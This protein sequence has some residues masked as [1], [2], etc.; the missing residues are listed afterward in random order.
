MNW[1]L[2]VRATD[3]FAAGLQANPIQHFWTLTVEEQFYL[4]WPAML[5]ATA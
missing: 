4:V 2:V 3:Y 1:S 5:L